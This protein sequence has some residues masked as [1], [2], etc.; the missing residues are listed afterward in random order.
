MLS[1]CRIYPSPWRRANLNTNATSHMNMRT[2]TVLLI[3]IQNLTLPLRCTQP[4]PH[5][6]PNAIA[7]QLHCCE[8]ADHPSNVHPNQNPNP[9]SF[10]YLYIYIYVILKLSTTGYLS[11]PQFVCPALRVNPE[12]QLSH[13]AAPCLVQAESALGEPFGQLQTQVS[14]IFPGEPSNMLALSAFEVY[15]APQRV[16]EN[17]VAF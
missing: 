12:S 17:L 8:F 10:A 13:M 5:P 16:W 7:K 2:L 9:D 15:H 14:T 3:S 11:P 1:A 4:S 6:V